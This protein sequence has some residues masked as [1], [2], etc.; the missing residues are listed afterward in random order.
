[1]GRVAFKLFLAAAMSSC[2]IT[3]GARECFFKLLL[4]TTK[5]KIGWLISLRLMLRG[6]DGVKNQGIEGEGGSGKSTGGGKREGGDPDP[7]R[8]RNWER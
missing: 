3:E 1:M 8:D 6:G 4:F 7:Q 2:S 5:M